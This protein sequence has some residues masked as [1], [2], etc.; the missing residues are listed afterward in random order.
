MVATKIV[1]VAFLASLASAAP[2]M[3]RNYGYGYDVKYEGKFPICQHHVEKPAVGGDGRGYGWE[4]HQSCIISKDK[5]YQAPHNSYDS[6]KPSYDNSYSHNTYQQQHNTYQTPS[7]TYYT[8]QRSYFARPHGATYY[9]QP[10]YEAPKDTYKYEEPKDTYK[11]EEQK[12]YG[13]DSQEEYDSGFPV[14]KHKVEKPSKDDKGRYY[15]HE[16][17]KSCIL[18]KE[19]YG[20]EYKPEYTPTYEAP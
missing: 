12:E 10:K 15:G 19:H 1:S 16:N 4:N 3:R 20:S 18:K 6:Y 9:E 5:Y 8:P 13:Y 17:G 14:C 7:N 2:L 11:Y